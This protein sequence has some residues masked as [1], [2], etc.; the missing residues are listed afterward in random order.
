MCCCSTFIVFI[1]LRT[2]AAAE[3]HSGECKCLQRLLMFYYFP[4]CYRIL[5][6]NIHED[7]PPPPTPSTATEKHKHPRYIHKTAVTLVAS[8]IMCSLLGERI[9]SPSPCSFSHRFWEKFQF[10]LFRPEGGCADESWSQRTSLMECWLQTLICNEEYSCV[11][12]SD[13]RSEAELLL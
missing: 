2:G 6:S 11:C 4:L 12:V 1:M 9:L 13:R 5:F 3:P 10:P 8:A 7:N